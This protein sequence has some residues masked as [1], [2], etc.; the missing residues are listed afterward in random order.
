[1]EDA[2]LHSW[3]PFRKNNMK[4]KSDKEKRQEKIDEL[5]EEA[6]ILQLRIQLLKI[7]EII[8]IQENWEY[9]PIRR[10]WWF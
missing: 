9:A 7:K 8:R 1:M 4:K 2:F 5:M 10:W 6:K 3:I